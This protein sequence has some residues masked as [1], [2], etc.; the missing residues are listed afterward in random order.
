[1]LNSSQVQCENRHDEDARCGFL[2]LCTY[3]SHAART[4]GKAE[5]L[6]HFYAFTFICMCLLRVV[7]GCFLWATQRWPRRLDVVPFAVSQIFA[8]T[9]VFVHLNKFRIV[10]FPYLKHSAISCRLLDSVYALN[11]YV[12][13]LVHPLITLISSFAPDSTGFPS[14]LR[15]IGRTNDW[16]TLTI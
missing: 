15:I 3:K 1:M 2:Q 6:L 12:S 14:F 10:T 13:N 5:A 8:C 9:I 4:L 7:R 16:L 11:K